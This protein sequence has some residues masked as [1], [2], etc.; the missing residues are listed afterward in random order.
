[1]WFY[2]KKK[3][4]NRKIDKEKEIKVKEEREEK[5]KKGIF[6]VTLPKIILRNLSFKVFSIFYSHKLKLTCLIVCFLKVK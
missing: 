6:E 1:M 2:L 3:R 4:I 5:K